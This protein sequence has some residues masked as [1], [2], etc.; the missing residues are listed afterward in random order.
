MAAISKIQEEKMAE[1]TEKLKRV[2]AAGSPALMEGE[3][4]RLGKA[5]EIDEVRMGVM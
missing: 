4:L 5:N 1:A 3:I 2:L